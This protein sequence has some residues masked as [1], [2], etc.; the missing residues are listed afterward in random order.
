M[1][2]AFSDVDFL[3]APTFSSEAPDLG[4]VDKYYILEKP[5]LTT[6]FNVTGLPTV[7]IPVGVSK[8]GLPLGM[9]IAAPE[10]YDERLLGIAK[11]FEQH[12]EFPRFR[13]SQSLPKELVSA[14]D[15]R[16]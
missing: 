4:E 11:V 9:Q 13:Q 1:R 8:A 3:V 6:P 10:G 5:L 2:S 12:S 7:N 14:E 16:D 15:S